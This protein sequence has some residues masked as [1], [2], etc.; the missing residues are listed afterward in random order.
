[1]SLS[2]IIIHR[3]REDGPI[4][5]RDFMEMSLYYPDQGYY[6]SPRE[7]IGTKGDFYTAP[8]FTRLFGEMMAKQIEEMWRLLG[9][10]PFTI[11]EYGAG[12]GVLCRDMLDALRGNRRLYRDL[13][14]FIIEKSPSMREKEK[15]ILPDPVQWFDS[16]ADIPPFAGC[17]LSNEV[18]DNFSVHQVMMEEELMEIWVDYQDGFLENLRPA[19]DALKNYL[20]ELG[21]TL[22][23]G[24]RTEINL[25]AVEWMRAASAAL[26]RGFMLTIDYGHPSSV[27]YDLGRDGGTL[28]CYHQHRVN[29]CPYDHIGE[30]DITTHV[31]FSAL[32]HWGEVFGL[33]YAGFTNQANFLQGLG[34]AQYLQQ[35][36]G[37]GEMNDWTPQ[38]KLLL[39]RTLFMDMGNRFKVLAQYKELPRPALSGMR[40]GERL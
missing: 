18:V 38:Q 7:K 9:E 3:I 25:E 1:M 29:D 5:F 33:H 10:E 2:D 39:I 21:V 20:G 19:S 6:T 8:W 35:K 11:V 32:R 26:K 31:N 23:K 24:Y 13:S 36:E 40:I 4:S 16:I 15:S 34:V 27:L 22:P 28:A 14:Y 30:Q 12:T 37:A 17:I